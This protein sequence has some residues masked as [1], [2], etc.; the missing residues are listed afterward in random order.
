MAAALPA[1]LAAPELAMVAGEASGDLLA[2]LV[3]VQLRTARPALH[4]AGIGGPRMA[5]Q[6]FQAWWPAERL[7]V[8][9]FVEV[10][11]RLPEL[12]AIRR[13]LAQRLL[14]AP[15]KVFVGI[16]APDFNLGLERRLRAAGVPTVH[17]VSPSLW[18]WRRER[19]TRIAQSVEHMLCVFPFEP[20]IYRGSGVRATYVGHPLADVI[21]RVPDRAA[22]RS[23]LGLRHDAPLVALLPGSRQAEVQHLLP[24]FLQAARLIAARHT[25]C[26][27][28]LPVAGAELRARIEGEC[29]AHDGLRLRVLE[30]RSHDALEAADGVL[31][32][33]GTASL[34]AALYKRPMVIAYR[35]PWLSW[36]VLKGRNYLPWVGLPNILANRSLVPEL[37]QQA[38][39]P[40][41]LAEGLLAQWDDAAALSRLDDEFTALHD[42]LRQGCAQR[43]A[44]VLQAYL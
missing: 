6:G 17:F 15:P 26:E 20:E 27:F 10:F 35:M 22:A 5:A 18:A 9:G 23:R 1:L 43:V 19:L 39:T 42:R 40:Q 4:A 13:R 24:V 3:L 7:A 44:D 41:A 34:E 37:L 2:S 14:A 8:R 28:V 33:S 12:F 31:V 29:A 30:G 32:A 38:C 25:A 16:D 21:P 36:Q 11:G